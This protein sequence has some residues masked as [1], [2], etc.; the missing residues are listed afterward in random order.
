MKISGIYKIINKINGN[1][2]VGSSKIISRRWF[3]HKHGLNKNKHKNPHLQLAWNKYGENNFYIIVVEKVPVYILLSTEQ[4]YLDIAKTEQNKCY[5]LSFLAGRIEMTESVRNKIR[6]SNKRRVWTKESLLKLSKIHTGQQ[7]T[8]ETKKRLSEINKNK[9]HSEE[10]KRKIGLKSANRTEETLEKLRNA[11][12]NHI[13]CS[14]TRKKLSEL[15]KGE[16][17]SMYGNT[18]HWKSEKKWE[19]QIIHSFILKTQ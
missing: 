13:V 8:E 19:D 15:N 11:A 17:N 14:E 5:N 4:K 6:E 7:H 9:K 3:N 2:Y 18:I 16:K 10:T 12:K 1:I